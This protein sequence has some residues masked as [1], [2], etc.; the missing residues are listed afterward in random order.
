MDRYII[1]CFTSLKKN[2]C[3]L[4]KIRCFP[5]FTF[6]FLKKQRPKICVFKNVGMKSWPNQTENF[7]I[8]WCKIYFHNPSLTDTGLD[9]FVK[10]NFNFCLFVVCIEL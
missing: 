6:L 1:T 10:E 9:Q 4:K 7:Q 2:D 8:Y 3:L 5:T